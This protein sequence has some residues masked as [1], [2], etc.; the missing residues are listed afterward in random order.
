MKR[1]VLFVAL[2]MTLAVASLSLLPAPAT[3]ADAKS[4]ACEGLT[5]GATQNGACV[6]PA[7]SASVN[8]I[9]HTVIDIFGRIIGIAAVL[10]VMY[11][12]FQYVT[13]GGDSG[14][15]SS[16]KN[17]LIYAIVGLIVAAFAEV[18]VQFVVKRTTS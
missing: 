13:A 7:G 17:T 2:V 12:G 18:I 15:V 3:Y 8:S 4:D 5:G 11:S 6:P 16:A 9:L 1:V 14:K 10:M